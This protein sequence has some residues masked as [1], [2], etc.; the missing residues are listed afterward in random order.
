[1]LDRLYDECKDFK[2]YVDRY[3]GMYKVT[4]EQALDRAIVQAVAQYYIKEK[5]G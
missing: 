1:M 5:R 4:K 2:E 3:C